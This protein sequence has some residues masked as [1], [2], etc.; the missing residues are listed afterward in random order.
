MSYR[1]K[2]RRGVAIGSGIAFVALAVGSVSAYRVFFARPGESALAYLPQDVALAASIDLNPSPQQAMVF[3]KLDDALER[4]E[5]KDSLDRGVI[6]MMRDGDGPAQEIAKYTRRNGVVAAIP[7]ETGEWRGVML[8]A[9]S[10]AKGL[11][12][13]LRKAGKTTFYKGAQYWTIGPAEDAYAVLGDHLV[14]GERPYSMW[15]VHRVVNGH[16]ASLTQLKEFAEARA[17]VPADAN[18]MAFMNPK[19]A[20]DMNGK[21]P[22]DRWGTLSASIRDGGFEITAD[23]NIDLDSA[24]ELKDLANAKPLTGAALDLLPAGAVGAFAIAQPG[25]Y[26]KGAKSMAMSADAPED[27]EENTL[28]DDIREF[29]GVD[30]DTEI[31]AALSGNTAIAIYPST[32]GKSADAIALVDAANGANPRA[33]AEKIRKHIEESAKAEDPEAVPFRTEEYNGATLIQMNLED[34]GD[35]VPDVPDDGDG[36]GMDDMGAM[37]MPEP[38]PFDFDRLFEDKNLVFVASGDSMIVASSVE[39]AK[40]AVDA[41]AGRAPTMRTDRAFVPD[42]TG[43]QG[44]WGFHFGRMAKMVRA[45]TDESKM[46][47]SDRK[48]FNDGLNAV[49]KLTEPMTMQMRAGND[50]SLSIRMFIPMDY[51]AMVDILGDLARGEESVPD[52]K[53]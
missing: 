49:E 43:A 10:D 12:A 27:G 31:A 32:D 52:G 15:R 47:E 2:F 19:Y 22:M 30:A 33:L 42:L 46:S 41:A 28:D 20:K 9:I 18:I 11:D 13:Y 40:R 37:P 4:N 36:D 35:T 53:L 45:M 5:M 48:N 8:I 51:D 39:M 14:V 24:P 17:S 21:S 25:I 50:G 34:E 7:D 29:L 16:E 6:E 44:V 3:K 23:G 38:G 1:T 26:G